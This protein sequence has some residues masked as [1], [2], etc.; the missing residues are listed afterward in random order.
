MVLVAA[1]CG[2]TAVPLWRAV[3]AVIVGLG[4]LAIPSGRAP[5]R[6]A[7]AT[8][9][10]APLAW[11]ALR[12]GWAAP[13][14]GWLWGGLAVTAA[15]GAQTRW[16]LG[17]AATALG[18][19]AVVGFQEHVAAGSVGVAA[20]M[21]PAMLA[22]GWLTAVLLVGVPSGRLGGVVVVSA[23]LAA[24][25]GAIG[26]RTR[27]A[28]EPL[29]QQIHEAD[30]RTEEGEWPRLEPLAV[31]EAE[32]GRLGAAL[33]VVKAR[34]QRILA[35]TALANRA[36]A[37]LPLAWGWDPGP[38]LAS[39]V[40]AEVGVALDRRGEGGRAVGFLRRQPGSGSTHFVLAVLAAEQGNTA[41]ATQSASHGDRPSGVAIDPQWLPVSRDWYAGGEQTAWFWTTRPVTGV[42]IRA[43]GEAFE[44]LPQ[45][46]V[47]IGGHTW[48]PSDV[49]SEGGAWQW[50]VDLPP[51]PYRAVVAFPNDA[52]GPSGDRNLRDVELKL[53]FSD[54]PTP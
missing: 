7:V 17:M 37:G 21:V 42:E 50:A 44:G 41:L 6:V 10:L 38:G 11:P 25:L 9:V 14:A 3:G 52:A 15:V 4:L 48:G 36:G 13:H 5:V 30:L 39:P 47:A 49:P 53:V 19:G 18:I 24:G 27:L 28:E 8:V 34:P 29:L 12:L 35:G 23:G 1:L 54:K 32:Q 45:L 31:A 33:A 20:A 26:W 43:R 2:T 46:R 22:L 40:A 16:R 51:G